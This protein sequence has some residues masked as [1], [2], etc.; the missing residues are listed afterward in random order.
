MNRTW[1]NVFGDAFH[2][3]P[4]KWIFGIG[5]SEIDGL[6]L[7]WLIDKTKWCLFK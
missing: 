6:I 4:E 2:C 3:S 5:W 7:M 1:M